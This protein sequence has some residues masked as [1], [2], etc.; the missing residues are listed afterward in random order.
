MHQENSIVKRRRYHPKD[1]DRRARIQAALYAKQ[2]TVQ[3]LAEELG[4]DNSTGTMSSYIWGTRRS[5]KKECEIAIALG[6][7]WR[8]LFA[9]ESKT[10]EVAA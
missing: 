5:Y 10:K 1:W 3:Q 6:T 9:P 4:I 7:T 8:E 2:M